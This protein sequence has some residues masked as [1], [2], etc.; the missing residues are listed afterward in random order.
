[1][2][3]EVPV[4]LEAVPVDEQRDGSA[5]K[6]LRVRGYAI[7][8][9]APS[10]RM[11]SVVE[12]IDAKALD[13]LGELNALDVR[14]QA[15]HQGLALARTTNGTLRLVKDARGLQIEADLDARR[16]DARDLYHATERGDV[17]HM[18]FGF[19]IAPGGEV[20]TEQPDGTVRAHVTKIARLYEVTGCTFAAYPDTDLEAVPHEDDSEDTERSFDYSLYRARVRRER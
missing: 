2:K 10:E 3:R 16:G 18:S 6:V 4:W 20:L 17:S 12:T 11:G 14:M 7:V 8:W 19:R 5:G 15:E 13:H 1:M 9:N